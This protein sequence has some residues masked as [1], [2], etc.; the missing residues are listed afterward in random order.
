MRDGPLP[1]TG[2]PLVVD[3]VFNWYTSPI[4]RVDRIETGDKLAQSHRTAIHPLQPKQIGKKEWSFT[5]LES[6]IAAKV[7][8][9][10]LRRAG[11]KLER[12]GFIRAMES[13]ND[14]DVGGFKV[15]YGPNNHSGSQFVD[16]TI[17]SKDQKFV[18]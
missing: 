4:K 5:S 10:G 8:V 1:N 9:E 3:Q 6:F 12:E 15:S 7:M 14:Y 18:R 13:I 11:R 2:E 17:I 16:L